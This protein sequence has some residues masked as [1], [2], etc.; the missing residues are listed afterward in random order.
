[1]NRDHSLLSRPRCCE[2]C[3]LRCCVSLCSALLLSI[4]CICVSYSPSFWRVD[5][6]TFECL[7]AS[8]ALLRLHS[9]IPMLPLCIHHLPVPF[10][11]SRPLPSRPN[12]GH[13]LLGVLGVFRGFLG[14]FTSNCHETKQTFVLIFLMF[15]S[16]L[17]LNL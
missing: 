12:I 17:S 11:R 7:F 9:S 10:L 1:M 2:C 4:R 8:L 6:Y 14:F 3:V 13:P 16:Y 5:F 15:L